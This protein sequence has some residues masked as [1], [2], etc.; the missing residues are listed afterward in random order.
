MAIDDVVLEDRKNK[1]DTV[2]TLKTAK[3]KQKNPTQSP[4][5]QRTKKLKVDEETNKASNFKSENDS[6]EIPSTSTMWE[7]ACKKEGDEEDYTCGQ[8]P[9]KK[10]KT[11]TC[12]QGQPVRLLPNS[13]NIV[14]D[15]EMNWDI[16]QVC[17]VT[18][19]QLIPFSLTRIRVSLA[20]GRVE[21]FLFSFQFC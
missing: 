4:S 5:A 13:K 3:R 12:P 19:V 7:V 16:V 6:T 15:V 8:F 18:L 9:L 21:S 11:E 14:E 17:I 1:L 2:Q 20:K 10:I